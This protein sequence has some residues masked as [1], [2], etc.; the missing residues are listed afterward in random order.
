LVTN[1]L[2]PLEDF[3]GLDVQHNSRSEIVSAGRVIAEKLPWTQENEEALLLAFGVAHN[4]RQAHGVP[5]RVVRRELSGKARALAPGSITAARLKRMQSIRRKMQRSPLTL[6]QIQDIAGCRAIVSDMNG[7]ESLLAFYRSDKCA[8]R[9]QRENDYIAEPKVGGYRSHHLVLK[10]CGKGE[11]AQ[12][13]RQTIELQLRTRLQH[14]WATAVEA[15][16]LVRNEDLKGGIGNPRWLRFF[17]V[18]AAE[19]AY[20]EQQPLAPG[21]SENR[22]ERLQE[23]RELDDELDAVRS[24]ESWNYSIRTVDS[25]TGGKGMSFLIRYDN[26]AAT[27][28]ISHW[29]KFASLGEKYFDAEIGGGNAILVDVDRVEDLKAAFPNYFLDVEMFVARLKSILGASKP[30]AEPPKVDIST[31]RSKP[32]LDLSWWFG[33]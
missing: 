11:H 14:S 33:S 27:V 21:V 24:L 30:M 29:S 4:W 28:T 10:F 1:R 17:N 20:A 26:A 7:V 23:L 15:V 6:Y 9:I 22:A 13:S 19:F 3:A 25:M 18:I 5:M 12:F 16:G 2:W 8:H 31:P 32:A